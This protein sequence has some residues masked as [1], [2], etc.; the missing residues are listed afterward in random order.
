LE[1]E[2][3]KACR[4]PVEAVNVEIPRWSPP[5]GSGS[6]P[7]DVDL[8]LDVADPDAWLTKMEGLHE[9][10]V[11]LRTKLSSQHALLVQLLSDVQREKSRR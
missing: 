3:R 7:D 4:S 10:N 9:E 11:A 8:A 6:P 2:A 1:T 5:P